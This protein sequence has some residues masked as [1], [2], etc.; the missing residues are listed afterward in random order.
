MTT[1]TR[2]RRPKI[3]RAEFRALFDQGMTSEELAAHYGAHIDSI[4]KI[5]RELG[6]PARGRL[7]KIDRTK[8]LELHNKGWTT[9]QL[10]KHF[11]AHI[12]SVSRAKAELGIGQHHKM[13]PERLATLA[14]MVEDGWSFKEIHRTEGADMSTLRKYFPGRS[15]TQDQCTEYLRLRRLENP[16]QHFN[17]RPKHYDHTK[18]E[19]AA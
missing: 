15:W 16:A 14:K 2:A 5:R 10:A 4:H 19:Q 13:T 9:T 6:I 3:D 8:L 7:A 18:Y 11:G 17:A 1:S 12:D